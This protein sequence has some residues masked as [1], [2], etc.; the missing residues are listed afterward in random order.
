MINLDELLGTIAQN[1][2]KKGLVKCT[3]E[4]YLKH[5]NLGISD[6]TYHL[7]IEFLVGNNRKIRVNFIT[8][9]EV[10]VKVSD[11][12]LNSN[13][14]LV[15]QPTNYRFFDLNETEFLSKVSSSLDN[16]YYIQR[17]YSE[18]IKINYQNRRKKEIEKDFTNETV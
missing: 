14:L 12:T 2:E 16:I 11:I 13:D 5:L 10:E 15:V 3:F 7:D 4:K 18:L 9:D 6:Y 1:I 8:W 17:H